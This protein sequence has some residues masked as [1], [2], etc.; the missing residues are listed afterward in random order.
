M[1]KLINVAGFRGMN[2]IQQSTNFSADKSGIVTPQLIL[3]ADVS[4]DMTLTKRQ[5][6][7]KLFSLINAHSLSKDCSVLLCIA[8]NKLCRLTPGGYVEICDVVSGSMSYAESGNYIYMSSPVWTGKYN[9]ISGSVEEWGSNLPPL[10]SIS[11]NSDGD[12]P[13]GKYAICYTQV[14]SDGLM[15]GNGG[16]GVIKFEGES[17]G[18][19]LLNFSSSYRCWITDTNGKDFYLADVQSDN[20][21]SP[22]Y[23]IPLQ[24]M[25]IIPPPKMST[26]V[27]T[28]GR[29]WGILDRYL[30]YS[31]PGSYDWFKVS[32]RFSFP[33]NLVM[34]A[35]TQNGIFIASETNTWVL[36]GTDPKKMALQRVGDGS[37]IGCPAYGNFQQSGQEVPTW[38]HKS[39]LPIW[40]GPN[41]FTVGNEH[42]ELTSL[43]EGR[44]KFTSGVKAAILQRVVNGQ[45]QTLIS[46]PVPTGV[47]EDTFKDGRVFI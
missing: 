15:S 20:I 7:T 17:K 8:N 32:N 9:L 25:F 47:L 10:P 28:F 19:T 23:N 16:I 42:F 34:I 29:I 30:Y 46:M 44:L 36:L 38:R 26:I 14:N 27:Y 13:P 31:E 22:Y 6:Y 21:I 39:V 37:I 40:L 43:T 5:G 33:D 41:G 3:N 2:N 18:I 35:P 1:G 24:S 4:S 45:M 11:L 12:L